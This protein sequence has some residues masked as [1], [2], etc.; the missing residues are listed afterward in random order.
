MDRCD[1][2]HLLQS[3]EFSVIQERMPP[4]TSE[5][6]HFHA[7]SRQFFYVISGTLSIL[8][9]GTLHE[10]AAEQGLEVAPK[11]PIVYPTTPMRMSDSLSFLLRPHTEI[12]LFRPNELDLIGLPPTPAR[13]DWHFVPHWGIRVIFSPGTKP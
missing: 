13:K 10:L 2:W 12:K 8:L 11:S 9:D 7:W 4:K 1:G 5:V 6:A 3:D